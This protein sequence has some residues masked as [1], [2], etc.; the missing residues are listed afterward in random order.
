M[1]LE[2]R[3]LSSPFAEKAFLCS[4]HCLGPNRHVATDLFNDRLALSSDDDVICSSDDF[5]MNL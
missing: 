3:H 2:S 5:E 1:D 4:D